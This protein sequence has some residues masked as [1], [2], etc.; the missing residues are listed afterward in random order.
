MPLGNS[1]SIIFTIRAGHSAH[2][3][4]DDESDS[5]GCVLDDTSD[6]A[7]I[8]VIGSGNT[9]AKICPIFKF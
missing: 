6:N 1:K 9:L 2:L 8:I 3:C 7:Y 5:Q 4:L